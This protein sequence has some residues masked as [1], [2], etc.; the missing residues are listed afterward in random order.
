MESNDDSCANSSNSKWQNGEADLVRS[1]LSV[2]STILCVAAVVLFAYNKLYRLFGYRLILYLLIAS[3]MNSVV[4]SLQ[5]SFYW[6]GPEQL[7]PGLKSFCQVLG[8]FE[9]YCSWNG[10]LTIFFINAD[11]FA[12]ATYRHELTKVEKTCTAACFGLPFF[13]AL[14]PLPSK[15]NYD[16]VG[17]YCVLWPY[18]GDSCNETNPFLMYTWLIPGMLITGISAILTTVA[19]IGLVYQLKQMKLLKTPERE[20]LIAKKYQEKY[21]CVLRQTLPLVIYSLTFL[22]LLIVDVLCLIHPD[23][24][25]SHV[26]EYV[27]NVL[28]GCVGGSSATVFFIHFGIRFYCLKKQPRVEQS[29][30]SQPINDGRYGST[31]YYT[32]EDHLEENE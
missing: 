4:D 27:S 8:Y 26:V 1:S 16:L 17:H 6:Y 21:S 29:H 24:K 3:M 7:K 5:M 23:K 2:V 12:V 22:V 30:L 11:I 10:L 14:V 28:T 31:S 13:I 18:K 19:V 9:M 32:A 25:T 20:E 15:K